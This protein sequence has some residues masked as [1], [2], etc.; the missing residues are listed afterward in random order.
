MYNSCFALILQIV[1]QRHFCHANV[2]E[3]DKMEEKRRY[4]RHSDIERLLLWPKI[5]HGINH[6]GSEGMVASD[7]YGNDDDQY[8]GKS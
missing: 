1:H 7:T 5:L 2:R 3:T 4:K 8:S 6:I